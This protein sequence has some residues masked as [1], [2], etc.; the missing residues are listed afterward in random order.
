MSTTTFAIEER[1]GEFFLIC[2]KDADIQ[3]RAEEARRVLDEGTI[4]TLQV[5]TTKRS[6]YHAEITAA[7]D[8]ATIINMLARAEYHQDFGD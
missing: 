6:E 8:L 5:P 4:D 1:H 2:P 7:M 3:Q